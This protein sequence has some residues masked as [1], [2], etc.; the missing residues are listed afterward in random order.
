MDRRTSAR[1]QRILLVEDT[2]DVR[3]MWRLWLTMWGFQV[4]EA[5]NG[6]EAVR[7]A[8]AHP[9]DLVLMDL[10]MPVLDGMEATR[11]LRRNAR[12]ATVPIIALT[13]HLCGGA[14][15]EA[16]KSGCDQF[17]AKPVCP[18][19]LLEHIRTEF[20]RRRASRG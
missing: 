17:V 6:A 3:E 5:R 20:A 1:P 9:P 12:T 7:L 14:A 15:E 16:R 18:D 11:Q 13:A 2:D 19:D 10:S 4:Q 8:E